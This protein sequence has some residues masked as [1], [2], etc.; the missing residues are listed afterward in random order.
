MNQDDRYLDAAAREEGDPPAGSFLCGACKEMKHGGLKKS[1]RWI[2][3]ACRDRS[4]LAGKCWRCGGKLDTREAQRHV[5]C[6]G[7]FYE[8]GPT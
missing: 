8:E 6:A 1:G 2:C 3:W 5:E 4:R 7:C